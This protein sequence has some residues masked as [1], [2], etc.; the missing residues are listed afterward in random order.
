MAVA[1]LPALL[2]PAAKADLQSL[3]DGVASPADFCSG[4]ESFGFVYVG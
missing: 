2:E 3:P 1:P 4:V